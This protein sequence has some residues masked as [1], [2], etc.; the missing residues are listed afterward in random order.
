VDLQ[1]DDPQVTIYIEQC[2]YETAVKKKENKTQIYVLS[3]I[4]RVGFEPQIQ[5]FQGYK[6]VRPFDNVT[7][8]IGYILFRL[9]K[10]RR[11]LDP[12][13]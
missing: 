2:K 7:G 13:T 12:N 3:F 10:L 5:S 4:S 11:E 6:I 9:L 1:I 8:L